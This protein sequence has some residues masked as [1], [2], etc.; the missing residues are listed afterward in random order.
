MHTIYYLIQDFSNIFTNSVSQKFPCSEDVHH[1]IYVLKYIMKL[2]GELRKESGISYNKPAIQPQYYILVEGTPSLSLLTQVK[3][4]R[5][6]KNHVTINM[7]IEPIS[8]LHET[9][10]NNN[11]KDI[12]DNIN[13]FEIIKAVFTNKAVN[14]L[15]LLMDPEQHLLLIRSLAA[16]R[17]DITMPVPQSTPLANKIITEAINIKDIQEDTENRDL[18]Q[19]S[20]ILPTEF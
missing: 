2:L 17:E 16:M 4:S 7:K 5:P 8:I 19:I 14:L 3:S 20:K 13:L 11:N 12:A 1:V 10:I 18:S 9:K 6:D 15:L